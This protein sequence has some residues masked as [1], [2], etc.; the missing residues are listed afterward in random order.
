ME[1]VQVEINMRN[2]R[3]LGDEAEVLGL[4]LDGARASLEQATTKWAKDHWQRTID[5]LLVQWRALPIMHDGSAVTSITPRWTV[6]YDF[7]ERDH[8][9]GHSMTDRVFDQLFREP[10]L[11]G[12]WN[13]VREQ[14]LAR[15]QY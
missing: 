4:R 11:E 14:R 8:G 13:R 9:I 5:Q 3:N 2:Y 10:D 12:S 1:P 6:N 15:C 7:Y